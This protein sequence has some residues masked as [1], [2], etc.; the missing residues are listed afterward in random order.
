M[1]HAGRAD[2]GTPYLRRAIELEPHRPALRFNLVEALRKAGAYETALSELRTILASEPANVRAWERAGDVAREQQDDDGAVKAWERACQLDPQALAPALKLATLAIERSRFDAALS[3][4]NPLAERAAENE[5]IYALWCQ[6]LVGLGDWRALRETA[7]SWSEGHP[8]TAEAWRNLA[9]AE[10]E[11]G[12][13]RKAVEA[14][15]RA[16]T[17]GTPGVGG[18]DGPCRSLPARAR[19]PGGR[20]RPGPG[21]C[22]RAERCARR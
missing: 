21:P 22:P 8:G 11:Q 18:S 19:F 20:G 3:V 9:R 12:R 15:G 16:L 14:H 10:F 7:R 2:E 5:E 1:L 6:A 17:L 4:L 13:H